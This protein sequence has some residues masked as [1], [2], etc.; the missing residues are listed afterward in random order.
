[1]ADGFVG[2]LEPHDAQTPLIMVWIFLVV[3][4]ILYVGLAHY[5]EEVTHGGRSLFFPFEPSKKSVK[6][7]YD[8]ELTQSLSSSSPLRINDSLDLANEAGTTDGSPSIHGPNAEIVVKMRNVSRSFTKGFF[9]SAP[10]VH[11]LTNLTVSMAKDEITA[12][13]GQNGAGKTTAISI[14][15]GLF[16]PSEGDATR[17]FAIPSGAIALRPG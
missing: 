5:I 4:A 16:P 11:A 17:S 3:D 2:S 10:P 12:L 8:V 7:A 1:M 13:L 9:S 6:A 14:L 15:T